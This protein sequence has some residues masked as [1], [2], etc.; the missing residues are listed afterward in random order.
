M[1]PIDY[2]A[3]WSFVYSKKPPCWVTS[4]EREVEPSI[5]Q[6][7]PDSCV[8]HRD[9]Y[10]TEFRRQRQIADVAAFLRRTRLQTERHLT[11]GGG[12][13]REHDE[14]SREIA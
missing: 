2:N 11:M 10:R 14:T 3:F 8:M 6:A 7:L 1:V 12:D 4:A 9:K 5:V 13:E